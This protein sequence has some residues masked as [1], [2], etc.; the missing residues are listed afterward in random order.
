L[1]RTRCTW[2]SSRHSC[3]TWSNLQKVW[4]VSDVYRRIFL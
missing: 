4:G 1:Q 3:G 2:C